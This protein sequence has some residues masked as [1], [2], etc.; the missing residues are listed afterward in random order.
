MYVFSVSY[1]FVEVFP[2]VFT[3][4]P[5]PMTLYVGKQASIQCVVTGSTPLSVVWQKDNVSISSGENYR[6]S[7][8]KNR[9]TLEIVKL[10]VADQGTYICKASNIVGTDMCCTELSVIDKPSFVKTLTPMT[11]AVGNPLRL[12]VLFSGTPPLTIKWFKDSK[13]ILSSSQCAIQKDNTSSLLELFFTKTS[14]SGEYSCEICN[15]V[16]SE[17]CQAAFLFYKFIFLKYALA[18]KIHQETRENN[19]IN[20]SRSRKRLRCLFQ[21]PSY[22]HAS[23]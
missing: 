7:V 5:E 19:G 11:V 21:M 4:K 9:Y 16:G 1:I 15:D 10:Q 22:R 17:F 3:T 18:S 8:D 20:T 2:P 12:D 13:E 14:D 6:A 23:V